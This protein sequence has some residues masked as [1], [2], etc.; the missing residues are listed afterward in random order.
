MTNL[1][2]FQG[3]RVD[4][5]REEMRGD[6]FRKGFQRLFH[7]GIKYD[8][9]SEIA[10][11]ILLQ[12]YVSNWSPCEGVTY[13]VPIGFKRTVDFYLPEQNVFVE[14]HPIQFMHEMADAK[15]GRAIIN[16]LSRLDNRY[17]RPLTEALERELTVQY[18]RKRRFTLDYSS[19]PR[20]SSARLIVAPNAED[21]IELVL[22][23]NGA[24]RN[25]A[26]SEFKRIINSKRI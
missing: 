23:P 15:A 6:N 2:Q 26:L 11:S 18:F 9:R 22:V 24:R 20:Y 12:R 17:R 7:C 1:E 10:C 25:E 5:S 3:S 16:I 4:L 14:Y 21:F 13:R 8:S 19:N